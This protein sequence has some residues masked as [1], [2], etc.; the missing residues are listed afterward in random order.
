MIGYDFHPEAAVDLEEI[1]EFIANDSPAAADRL[2]AAILNTIE[3]LVP[4]PQ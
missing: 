1:W 3:A 2:I 4:F